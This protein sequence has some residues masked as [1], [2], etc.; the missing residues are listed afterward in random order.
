[1]DPSLN[2]APQGEQQNGSATSIP[3]PKLETP[4]SNANAPLPL[5]QQ[6]T[7][8]PPSQ[9]QHGHSA[10]Q[11]GSQQSAQPLVQQLAQQQPQHTE[12]RP[13]VSY[14]SSAGYPSPGLNA[15]NN[16]YA[17]PPAQPQQPQVGE[18]YRESPTGSNGS[19]SLPSMRSLDPLQQQQG[20]QQ[21]QQQVQ[22]GHQVQQ[23]QQIQQQQQHMGSP[24]PPPNVAQMPYY[25]SAQTLPHPGHQVNAYPMGVSMPDVG[26]QNMRYALPPTDHRVMSGGR[27]KKV[28]FSRSI[29]GVPST[30]IEDAVTHHRVATGDQA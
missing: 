6:N 3:M 2:N 13:P 25:H 9:V 8:T 12:Q 15:N 18:P 27:H 19:L 26:A 4:S 16:Q 29:F 5:P 20:V 22:Q 7:Q 10:Q 28:C 1:M 21:V 11:P 23:V 24:L 17:Y 14:P 30:L